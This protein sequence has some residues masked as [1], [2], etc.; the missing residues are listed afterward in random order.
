MP[1]CPTLKGLRL[2]R[3]AKVEFELGRLIM[4][5]LEKHGFVFEGVRFGSVE[6]QYPVD[7]KR[8]DL[9]LFL[10]DG[11]PILVIETKRKY[12]RSERGRI[13]SVVEQR[14][15]PMSR[16]VIEQAL[17]YAVML[18][19]PFFATTNGRVFA[20]FA[21]PERGIPF[22]IE[23][24][25]IFLEE[26][27]LSEEFA[28]ELLSM[29]AKLC[30]RAP[31]SI[32]PLDW[33]FIMRLRSFVNWLSDMIAPRIRD[34]LKVDEEFRGL[35]EEFC[36]KTGCKPDPLQLAKEM[37]YILMNKVVFY[38]ILERY[39]PQLGR[40]R[41]NPISAPDANTYLHILYSFFRKAVEITRN[42]EPVFFTG[43][44]DEVVIPDDEIVL[45]T[46]NAFIEDM[47][48]Y[49]L[50]ELSSDIVGFIYEELI[51]AEERHKFGQF[52][53]PPAI[54]ELIVKW[55]VRE[56]N[57][58]VLDPG[59]GSGTFLI[60]AYGQLLRLKG[61][62]E[63]TERAH[64]E[65][66]SQLY[67]VD[68]N[69]FP[70]HLT[71]LN[72]ASRYIRAPVTEMN[73][74][75]SDFFKLAPGQLAPMPYVVKTPAGEVERS[76]ELPYF[77]AVVG[78]PPYTRWTEI[79]DETKEA[80]RH[81]LGDLLTRYG[82]TAQVSRGVEP[83]IYIHFIMHAFRFLKPG[84][85]LGIIISDSWLQTDYGVNFGR[86]LLENFKIKALIDISVRVFPIPLI[87]SCILLLEKP[88]EGE[89]VR[90]NEV[91]FIY[92][93]VPEGGK[94]DVD[95][96]LRVI[97]E[98]EEAPPHYI[99]RVMRQGDIPRDQKWINF[100]FRPEDVLEELEQKTIKM[101]ELFEA[102]RGN[103][104][105]AIWA[106]SR[107][108]RPDIGAKGFFYL[109]EERARA[110]GL[111][112]YIYPAI[113]SARYAKW[114]T[115][116]KADWEALRE[117]GSPCYFFMCHKPKD[118]LPDNVKE[119]IRW[120]EPVCPR[121]GSENIEEV[122]APEFRCQDCGARFT[123]CITRI[124][125]ARGGGRICSQALACR[126]REK[127]KEHFY[128]WYDLGGVEEAPIMAIYQSRYKTRFFWC[129]YP[130][131]TYH[132]IITFIPKAELSEIQLKA[133]LAYLNSSFT[134]LYIEARGRTTGAV[135]PIALEARQAQ[136]IPVID[137]RELDEEA[138]RE[139]AALFDK[140]ERRARELGG[141]DRR[142][143]I[144]ELWDTVIAEIDYKVAEV[145]GLPKALAD[146]ARQ[147][148][149][150][151]MERRLARAR[152]ARP[153][154]IRGEEEPR[155]RRSRRRREETQR[156]VPLNSF[157]R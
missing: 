85:R 115:F 108:R 84:G 40:H 36:R 42:F 112:D 47:D 146:V 67:A 76:I 2:S 93:S 18:G 100:I 154:V 53:T 57:D 80:I 86:F 66:L 107:G 50:E 7:R 87:G 71:A 94:F 113:T 149:K 141:A 95:E 81:V 31:V 44:Y 140:L 129:K 88:R 62:M 65:I 68:I 156:G 110:L 25:R 117:R 3:E 92:L 9:V 70:L 155:L 122:G 59:C 64:R 15:D 21:T 143:N 33:T 91:V 51:P 99:V 123:K 35:Y 27:T 22:S 39:Y 58:L 103:Y 11:R 32:T 60:K 98:P 145:L 14:I 157:M 83:G 46:I 56:P 45:E 48:R 4:N 23:R 152:E 30:V 136:E 49:R 153:R 72:L 109:T 124:P 79:P 74:I 78:N 106:L 77:D 138:L 5:V 69:P 135:G 130:A 147:L 150:T 54:A 90:E 151:M 148:A 114:F 142:E 12:E 89:D 128:G 13:R 41:L 105:Y 26:I 133:L 96:I 121:C 16:K 120:G 52:Y 10:A 118:D 127:Q 55:A 104:K 144:M 24:H 139:L 75:L 38:K 73:T 8:A 111:T 132:A 126:E 63:P 134:Q 61:Y 17:G 137:P 28:E 101:G 116:T 34:R 131:V 37:A 43:I 125:D 119:Y 1:G 20:L 97:E 29:L 82:L 19:A 6:P 102:S